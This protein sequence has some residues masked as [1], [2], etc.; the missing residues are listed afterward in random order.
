MTFPSPASQPL[1]GHLGRWGNDPLDLLEEGATLGPVFSLRLWRRAIVGYSPDWNR[2]IL[3]DLDTFRSKGSMSGLSPYLKGGLVGTDAPDHRQARKRINPAF[4]RGAVADLESAIASVTSPRLPKGAFDAREWSSHLVREV[5]SKV[6]FDDALSA[7]L[8][9]AFLDPLD[10]A[11]PAPL[12][13]R[14][15]LFRR[16]NIALH[17]LLNTE[18]PRGL[19]SAF[20]SMPDAVDQARVALSAAY[21]TTAH[22]LAWALWHLATNP[23]W[24]HA[25]V[26]GALTDEALRLYPSGWV[27]SRVNRD[28]VVFNDVH[29]PARTLLLYSPYLTHRDPSLWTDPLTFTPGRA[30]EPLPAWGYI[31]FAAGER[32]CL[33]THLAKLILRTVVGQFGETLRTIGSHPG[34]RAGIT[35]GPAGPIPLHRTPATDPVPPPPSARSTSSVP[36][37]T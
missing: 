34:L 17:H 7:G 13:R 26:V 20:N 5:L 3:R 18:H 35:L 14:P 8:L 2:L 22:T 31:P 12:L 27:G 19:I 24:G 36:H 29:I 33:G 11:L 16:M 10:G 1:V 23:R 25:E 32:T 4:D 28:P 37:L 15:L 6:F 21:D 30:A 9:Q